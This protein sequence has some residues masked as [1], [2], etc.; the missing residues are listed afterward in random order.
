MALILGVGGDPALVTATDRSGNTTT[1]MCA[2][3]W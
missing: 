2:W 1:A 3:P